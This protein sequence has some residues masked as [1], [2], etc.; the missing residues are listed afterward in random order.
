M[1][2]AEAI[3]TQALERTA[4]TAINAETEVRAAYAR[5]RVRYEM[6]RHVQDEIVPLR[7]RI[8]QEHQLRYNGM[9][10]SAFELLAD[11]RE[12]VSS[13]SRYINA[14]RDFWLADAGLTMATMGPVAS[15][16][17]NGRGE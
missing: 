12:Q 7:K 14:V 6:A 13:V 2:R 10:L 5:Y 15:V 8:L 1:K 11:A 9:L 17:A 16:D 3:Y 4:Q